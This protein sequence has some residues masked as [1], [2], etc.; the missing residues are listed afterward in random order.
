MTFDY[1]LSVD[2]IK[3]ATIMADVEFE[4]GELIKLGFLRDQEIDAMFEC[5][6]IS[7]E[8]RCD[9]TLRSGFTFKYPEVSLQIE[10]GDSYPA[11]NLGYQLDNILLP[12][13]TV[14]DL[15]VSLRHIALEADKINSIEQ[16]RRRDE[17]ENF[18]CFHFDMLALRLANKTE[19]FLRT[20]R[21]EKVRLEKS[22][23]PVFGS[24]PGSKPLKG[25]KE[26]D[27]LASLDLLTVQGHEL[28]DSLL[29][30]TPDQI[31]EAIPEEFRILHIEPVIRNDLYQAF[32]KE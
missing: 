23:A 4:E 27:Y 11:M 5:G 10:T 21:L 3:K 8:G 24:E 32:Q 12:R 18:G 31:C 6:I 2:G 15:R 28:V 13:L 29:G 14:D 20:Y 22:K 25:S 1:N 26:S 30:R 17:G 7:K 9:L 19:D 16:W